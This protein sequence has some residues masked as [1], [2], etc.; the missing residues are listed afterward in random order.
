MI[1]SRL[2][3]LR[4]RLGDELAASRVYRLAALNWREYSA[5][6]GASEREMACRAAKQ[7]HGAH[8]VV[9]RPLMR[10]AASHATGA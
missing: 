9:L 3:V 8:A 7:I 4:R 6:E 5:H 1:E 10:G 2:D